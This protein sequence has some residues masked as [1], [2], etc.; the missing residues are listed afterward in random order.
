MAQANL[1]AVISAEDRAS[2]TIGGVGASFGKLT[3][4]FAAGQLAANAISKA[5]GV[6]TDTVKDSVGAAFK[7]VGAVE[8]AT[9]ALR[10]YE[11]NG[12]KVNK[13]LKDLIAYARSDTGV[14]FQREDLFAAA[15]TLK[16]YG[17]S[18]ETLTD[19]VKIL[20]KG[21]SLGKTTF[22]ELSSI[23]GRAAAKGRLDAVDFDMLIERGIGLD[24][25]MRGATVTSEGL[26]KALDKALPAEL[27]KGRAN[28]IDGMMIRLKSSFRDV[29]AA[30]LGVD[31][32]TTTFIKGGLGDTFVQGL[33]KAR[34]ALKKFA[35]NVRKFMK[36]A[37]IAV[38]DFIETFK[39]PDITS[40]GF[41]GVIER[42]ASTTRHAFDYLR[43]N[44]IKFGNAVKDAFDVLKGSFIALWTTV[45]EDLF[46]ALQRLW[47]EVLEPLIP[48]IGA[49]LVAS[50]WVL[51]N[52]LNVWYKTLSFIIQ[53]GIN[54]KVFFA[55]TL[56]KAITAAFDFIVQKV[57]W[58]KDNFWTTIGRI[59]GFFATLPFKLPL[60]VVIAFAKIVSFIL[61]F[62]W[63]KIF[64]GI[65]QAMQSVWD[66][67]TGIVVKAWHFIHD[68]K[69][70]DIMKG[71]GKGIANA[72]IGLIEGAI[73]G[74]ISGIP[75]VGDVRLPRFAAG[76]RDFSGGSALV[77]ENGPERVY[78]PKGSSVLP[79]SRSG[80]GG[81]V[82]ITVQAGAYMGNK[83]DARKYAQ[84]IFESLKDVAQSNGMTMQQM[85]GQ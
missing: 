80:G 29:G 53:V 40:A 77:G 83:Q 79:H 15:Q 17:Q 33:G 42:V 32:D 3:A 52:S 72:I 78:L 13:V 22:Q 25:S 19:K 18:T 4:A 31:Q 73:N 60:F 27:L 49:L 23:V 70:G 75:G 67:I 64:S 38:T 74:A 21:V 57:L 66:K 35:P 12:D 63:S 68:L 14:L 82:N 41:F 6:V 51:I 50:I 65:W 62:K 8:N 76:V 84:M 37:I 47:R 34:G 20:S 71:V 1:K 69:W 26:F 55:S 24:K 44:A 30:I 59:I 85:I 36:I 56:P 61:S 28:T 48:I 7:Q 16:L 45:V 46:P 81:S 10:A 43:E 5:I 2:R 58:L 39:D 11:K 54:M 9:I